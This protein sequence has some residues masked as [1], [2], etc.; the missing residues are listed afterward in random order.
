MDEFIGVI[1]QPLASL[2]PQPTL[3]TGMDVTRLCRK[4]EAAIAY[5]TLPDAPR[6]P[7]SHC[8][9]CPARFH[10]PEHHAVGPVM[11]ARL[12]GVEKIKHLTPAELK[13]LK[14]RVDYLKTMIDTFDEAFKGAVGAGLVP[15]WEMYDHPAGHKP[16]DPLDLYQLVKEW[17]SNKEFRALLSC[18]VGKIRDGVISRMQQQTGVKVKDARVWWDQNIVPHLQ[19]LPK[20]RRVRE[21][22]H[23]T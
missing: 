21:K 16:A 18:P 14:P 10:C 9:Y 6:F 5:S 12:E 17:M 22:K 7:G 4:I 1:S 13:S 23:E 15:G 2:Y 19:E 11:T 3:I 20:Q 8:E